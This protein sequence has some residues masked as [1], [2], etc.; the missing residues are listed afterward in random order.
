[1]RT[2]ILL[3]ILVFLTL[4]CEKESPLCATQNVGTMEVTNNFT[5]GTL[6]VYI[7]TPPR[8]GN[9]IGDISVPAGETKTSDLPT[10]THDI[11]AILVVTTCSGSRCSVNPSPQKDKEVEIKQCST[12]SIF[13]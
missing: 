5:Q 1:M 3:S 9:G 2:F 6:Q 7:D 4:A 13:Y 11:Y 8:S 12:Q 10:G